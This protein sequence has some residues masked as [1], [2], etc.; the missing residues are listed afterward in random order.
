MGETDARNLDFPSHHN[1]LVM[2]R[3]TLSET[4]GEGW[5]LSCP[6]LWP[7][8]PLVYFHPLACSLST[9]YQVFCW[10]VLAQRY[11]Q[12]K[13][14]FF[15]FFSFSIPLNFL[16]PYH[17]GTTHQRTWQSIQDCHKGG[18]GG[19]HCPAK[20]KWKRK[21]ENKG[22]G[23]RTAASS[24]IGLGCPWTSGLARPAHRGIP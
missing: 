1:N 2:R 13:Y 15:F 7:F 17:V 14:P 10:T 23:S 5:Q 16:P 4:D 21:E 20:G 18:A 8:H 6:L 9:A 12:K 24:W 22:A 3:I 19:T 11:Q